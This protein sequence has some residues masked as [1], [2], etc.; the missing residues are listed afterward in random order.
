MFPQPTIRI[1]NDPVFRSIVQ[2][3]PADLPL[4]LYHRCGA[5][6]GASFGRLG[7]PPGYPICEASE[8]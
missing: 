2:V 6:P 4:P 3:P 7:Y 8:K 5:R 1:L